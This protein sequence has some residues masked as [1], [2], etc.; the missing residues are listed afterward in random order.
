M[1]RYDEMRVPSRHPCA[2]LA[3]PLALCAATAGCALFS[4]VPPSVEVMSV[5]LLAE[6]GTDGQFGV[7]LCVTNPNGD[8]IVLDKVDAELDVAGA[9]LAAG[10]TNLAVRLPPRSFTAI[11]VTVVATTANIGPQIVRTVQTGGI[12]YRIRG[13]ISLQTPL[14]ATLAFS[15]SGRLDP[16]TAGAPLAATAAAPSRCTA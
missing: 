9:P 11:P 2:R 6:N 10:T 4:D 14:A 5:Q 3:A 12:D 8:E 7:T 1:Q 13:D 15:R 16:V